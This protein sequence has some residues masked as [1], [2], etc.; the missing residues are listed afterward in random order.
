MG[1]GVGL[2]LVASLLLLLGIFPSPFLEPFSSLALIALIFLSFDA[3]KSV[4]GDNTRGPGHSI[5]INQHIPI[6]RIVETI[7]KGAVDDLADVYA[8]NDDIISDLR[9]V[10][11]TKSLPVVCPSR[12]SRT[13]IGGYANA[14]LVLMLGPWATDLDEGRLAGCVC[15]CHPGLPRHW[16]GGLRRLAGCPGCDRR[17]RG[18]L[19]RVRAVAFQTSLGTE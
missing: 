1:T 5:R 6:P 16:A 19:S 15:R 9:Q 11:K 14:A 17:G 4:I 3:R 8:V 18:H 7:G 12:I 2:P 10:G 13:E